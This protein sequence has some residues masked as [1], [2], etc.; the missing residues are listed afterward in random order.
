[1]KLPNSSEIKNAQMLLP[2]NYD[3]LEMFNPQKRSSLR[4]RYEA[5]ISMV[6]DEIGRIGKVSNAVDIGCGQGNY[7][8]SFAAKGIYAIGID[9]RRTYI[10]YAKMK[11]EK[12]ERENSDFIIAN[13]EY[14]PFKFGSIDSAYVGELLEHFSE[15]K[16]VLEEL[17]RASAPKTSF[18]IFTTPNMQRFRKEK[19]NNY[20]DMLL[21]SKEK[22][23]G[24]K[25]GA[26]S[27]VFEFTREE[28][29]S[30]LSD[31]FDISYFSYLWL[32][33]PLAML[34]YRLPLKVETLRK[35]E[36]QLLKIGI[37][38]KKIAIDMVCITQ[39]K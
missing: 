7:T 21:I 32:I 30:V 35:I 4:L 11:A 10:K 8:L 28:M 18:L 17:S 26:D 31:Y 29:I 27:H 22:L 13:A 24:L 15:P 5:K 6:L 33:G 25:Y 20:S 23:D 36:T 37:L 39:H 34:F 14:L 3:K 19:I 38:A 2:Y 1:M 16:K 9:L 12:N